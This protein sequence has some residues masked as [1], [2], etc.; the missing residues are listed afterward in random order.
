MKF[1]DTKRNLVNVQL[2]ENVFSQEAMESLKRKMKKRVGFLGRHFPVFKKRLDREFRE[3]TK[4]LNFVS[5][6]LKHNHVL[7][8]LGWITL[9]NVVTVAGIVTVMF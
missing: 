3:F 8:S 7:P 1:S 6:D 2:S 4:S 9:A 5:Y